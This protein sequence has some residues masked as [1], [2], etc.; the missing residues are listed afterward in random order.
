MLKTPVFNRGMTYQS[1]QKG[2]TKVSIL[3][4]GGLSDIISYARVVILVRLYSLEQ[5]LDP[6]FWSSI[7]TLNFVTF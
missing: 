3:Y 5:C 2:L 6:M 1:K 4:W 7:K